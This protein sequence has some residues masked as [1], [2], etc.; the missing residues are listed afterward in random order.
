MDETDALSAM[1]Q[2]SAI[3]F[4]PIRAKNSYFNL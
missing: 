1:A 2:I 3:I 4:A